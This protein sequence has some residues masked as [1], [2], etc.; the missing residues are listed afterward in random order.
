MVGKKTKIAQLQQTQVIG[1]GG[2]QHARAALADLLRHHPPL[3]LR[4][5]TRLQAIEWG[6]AGAVFIAQRQMKQQVLPL[7]NA[8]CGQT[9][10]RAR[11]DARQVLQRQRAALAHAWV[12]TMTPSISTSTPRGSAAT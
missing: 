6:Q 3:H 10:Q 7:V 9:R 4:H 8:Q 1:E 5:L 2:Q 11:A 12:N